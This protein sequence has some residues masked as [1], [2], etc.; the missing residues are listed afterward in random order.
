MDVKSFDRILETTNLLSI[1]I[2]TD[3]QRGTLV[4]D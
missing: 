1:K 4:S 2:A 3:K